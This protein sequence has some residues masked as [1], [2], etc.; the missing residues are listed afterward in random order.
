MAESTLSLT[1]EDLRDAIAEFVYGGSGD[2]SDGTF[3]AQE[4]GVIERIRK[5]GMRLAYHPPPI[6]G[7]H[8]EWSFLSPVATLSLNAQITAGTVTYTHSNRRVVFTTAHTLTDATAPIYKIEIDGIDYTVDSRHDATNLVLPVGDNPGADVSTASTYR[9]HQ[10]DYT[11]PDD[12]S[13]LIDDFTFSQADNAWYTVKLVG[14]AR[15]RTMRQRSSNANFSSSDP[16][17]CAIR[18]LANVPA[19]GTRKEVIFWPNI[20][21]SA[22][23]QYR[24]RVRPD[25]ETSGY[26]YGA[27]DHSDMFHYACLAEA[28]LY[29]DHARGPMYERFSEALAASVMADSTDNKPRQL[30]YNGDS[31]DGMSTTGVGRH[32]LYGAG[33]TYK[34]FGVE[35]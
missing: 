11:L 12:F 8:H 9:L 25:A 18:P 15:I 2:Y 30:G 10:D 35:K 13:R 34:D 21:S 26:I 7:K 24:Y 23:V 29:L 19:T 31:S 27:S 22:T 14:E 16:Q 17:F 20:V 28:E 1:V 5:G 6:M 4:Q 3:T 33:V 32:Y